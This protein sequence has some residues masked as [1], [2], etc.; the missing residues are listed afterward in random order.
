MLAILTDSKP[1]IS[2]LR[3]LDNKDTCVAWV[4]GHKVIE[5]NEEVDKLAADK[6]CREASILGHE[7]G[8]REWS[9]L[10]AWSK[11]VRVETRGGSREL[12]PQKTP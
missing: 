9:G 10:R 6:L 2:T 4:Q 11:R 7:S 5:G 8:A 1:A 12:H 3:K